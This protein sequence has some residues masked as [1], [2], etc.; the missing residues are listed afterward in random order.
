VMIA[1]RGRSIRCGAVSGAVTLA[2]GT[3]SLIFKG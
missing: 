2:S 3:G 1:D